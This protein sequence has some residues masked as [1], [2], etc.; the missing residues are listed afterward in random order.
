MSESQG[1]GLAGQ[2][3][4]MISPILGGTRRYRGKSRVAGLALSSALMLVPS[5]AHAQNQIDDPQL[6]PMFFG[7]TQKERAEKIQKEREVQEEA[8]FLTS[9]QQ[10]DAEQ[11]DDPKMRPLVFGPH[12]EQD[13]EDL[14]AS[15]ITLGEEDD[16]RGFFGLLTF[17]TPDE[18]NLSLGVGP[19][20]RPD[21]FGSDDYE[22]NADP[23][24][25][26]KFKNFV[27]LDDDGADFALFGF[28]RFRFGPSIRIRGRRDQD[29]NIA[30]LGLGDVGTTFEFGGFAATTFLDRFAFRAKVRHG[31]KTGH[32]GTI[33]DGYLTALL[34]RAGGVSLSTSAQASWI[35]NRYAD[36]YFSVTPEQSLRSQGQLTPYD[37]DAGFRNI[38]A[39]V[40]GYINM[41]DR[42]SLN[43]YASWD[44][45]FN[46]Y[47][48]TPIIRDFG[49]RNQFRFGFHIMR[50]FTFGG[51]D[52]G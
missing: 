26:V 44:Y 10:R 36:A 46:D 21:Y 29:E 20:Y 31:L 9:E 52:E 40:N 1:A 7:P 17:L 45:I 49:D 13:A 32:R 4:P 15:R 47:A 38:G 41:G 42:W 8:L 50:E 28:S 51:R 23:Q 35:G 39:S 24:V 3:L 27:F 5:I 11:I 2:K 12:P 19:V 43:P 16:N 22:F 6:S 48:E 34:F 37:A 33:V 14:N 18:T 30:L 25:Y